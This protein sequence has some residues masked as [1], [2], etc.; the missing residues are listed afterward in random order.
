MAASQ[1][2]DDVLIDKLGYE[3]LLIPCITS[4]RA[5]AANFLGLFHLQVDFSETTGVLGNCGGCQSASKASRLR[6]T[7]SAASLPNL[8]VIFHF[9]SRNFVINASLLIYNYLMCRICESQMRPI[10]F[11][12]I[13]RK[14]DCEIQYYYIVQYIDIK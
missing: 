11:F 3:V 4:D 14:T 12:R 13:Q 1:F 2:F 5:C 6:R 8:G 9:G 10:I 7:L